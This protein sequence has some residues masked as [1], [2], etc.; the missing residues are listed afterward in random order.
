LVFFDKLPAISPRNRIRRNFQHQTHETVHMNATQQ[1]SLSGAAAAAQSRS[2][3]TLIDEVIAFWEKPDK[4]H[5]LT[6]RQQPLPENLDELLEHTQR[7]VAA[8]TPSAPIEDDQRRLI[9]AVA[10]FFQK[11]CLTPSSDHYR[12]LGLSPEATSEHV[13][14]RYH[15]L[16]AIFLHR[17]ADDRGGAALLRLSNAHAALS[18]PLAR[19]QYD[20]ELQK[21]QAALRH[22]APPLR[23]RGA[24]LPIRGRGQRNRSRWRAWG[25]GIAGLTLIITGVLTAQHMMSGTHKRTPVEVATPLSTVQTPPADP[26]NTPAPTV[27]SAAA[28]AAADVAAAATTTPLVSELATPPVVGDAS[29]APQAASAPAPSQMTTPPDAATPVADLQSRLAK[30]AAQIRATR[31]TQPPG[32]NALETYQSILAVDPKQPDALAGLQRIADRYVGLV[33][34]RINKH[35]YSAAAD[36]I[37]RGLLA[38]PDHPLLLKQQQQV[39]SKLPAPQNGQQ[40]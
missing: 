6:V 15:C 8:D 20:K 1:H 29:G 24:R 35:N 9:A 21:S 2:L 33:S 27:D 11:S 38:A 30:G 36:M 7:L 39:R 25:V 22:A 32:D 10:H 13:A 31:L 12:T 40:Q 28:S 34:Y 37:A 3:L 23:R 14:S 26:P 18:D 5:D 4:F 16:R 17:A 19:R